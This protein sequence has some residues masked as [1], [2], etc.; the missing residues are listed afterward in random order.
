VRTTQPPFITQIETHIDLNKIEEEHG[1]QMATALK[2]AIEYVGI[3]GGF[4]GF[5][6]ATC[7]YDQLHEHVQVLRK[8]Q[9][10]TEDAIA[11]LQHICDTLF[12][13]GL[14]GDITI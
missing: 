1:P 8:E 9:T 3:R 4:D 6:V 12:G 5:D 11:F 7:T 2:E 14:T 13:M 10:I